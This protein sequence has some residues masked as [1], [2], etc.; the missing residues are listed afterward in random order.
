VVRYRRTDASRRPSVFDAAAGGRWVGAAR[1]AIAAAHH[2]DGRVGYC[3]ARVHSVGQP[4]GRYEVVGPRAAPGP[5][6][7]GA[8]EGEVGF[9]ASARRDEGARAS[10][11]ASCFA[12]MEDMRRGLAAIAPRRPGGAA[13]R[14]RAPR[15]SARPSCAACGSA[16]AFTDFLKVL[17]G[18]YRARG[19][20]NRLARAHPTRDGVARRSQGKA[21]GSVTLVSRLPVD[22]VRQL[23]TEAVVGRRSNRSFSSPPKAARALSAGR[24]PV[25]APGFHNHEQRRPGPHSQRNRR[26]SGIACIVESAGFCRR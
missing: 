17:D 22:P 15:A 24:R 11:A 6:K 23:T 7:Q 21:G 10:T 26:W 1:R 8:G 5:S 19:P 25:A 13:S 9:A 20:R 3:R 12:A 2:T 14:T 18:S 4:G 16:K